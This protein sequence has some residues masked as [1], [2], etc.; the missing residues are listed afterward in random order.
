MLLINK[1]IVI[2]REQV[3]IYGEKNTE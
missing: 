3:G 2:A 1:I